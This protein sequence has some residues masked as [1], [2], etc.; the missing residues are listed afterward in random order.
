M[1]PAQIIFLFAPSTNRAIFKAWDCVPFEYS[2]TT[3]HYFL[4]ASLGIRCGSEEHQQVFAV[5]FLLMAIWPVGSIV[6]FAGLALRGRRR[7]LQ[8]T[9]D[10]FVR[11]IRFLHADFKPQYC[12]S[13]R[14]VR[15]CYCL[16]VPPKHLLDQHS[17]IQLPPATDF[18][19]SIE[20]AQRSILT[21]W[22]LLVH[23]EQSFL[24]LIVGLLTTQAMLVWT[25][26]SRPYRRVEDNVLAVAATL[27]LV[28]T[29]TCSILIKV[30]E[31]LSEATEL[32]GDPQLTY[33]VLGF[34]STSGIVVLLGVFALVL[35]VVIIASTL[36]SIRDEQRMPILRLKDSGVPPVLT[37]SSAG[38][39]MLFISHVWSTGQGE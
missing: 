2:A 29:Y 5:A 4:R 16:S 1:V 31:D 23:A 26:I 33:R 35:L 11:A 15:T 7:L 13:L 14:P 21:G 24:R 17:D 8:H 22:V 37:I 32:L 34:A 3:Q 27:L 12:E 18:W 20:L 38:R 25:L 28:L 19:A 39:W 10:S 36:S 9:P 6:V 30:H